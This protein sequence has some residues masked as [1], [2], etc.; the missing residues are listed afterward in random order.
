VFNLG[1]ERDDDLRN[2]A[3]IPT[4]LVRYR[5]DPMRASLID[6]RPLPTP[7]P[8]QSFCAAL[9]L[10]VALAGAAGGCSKEKE[11]LVVAA[12]T[13]ADANAAMKG[14]VALSVASVTKT[15]SLPAGLSQTPV[16]LGVY[17][18]ASVTGTV[19]ISAS[20]A[21]GDFCFSRTT[22]TSVPSAGSTVMVS[23]SLTATDTCPGI[24][25]GG[26]SGTGGLSETGGMSGGAG[27]PGTG[28]AAGGASGSSGSGGV[29][30]AGGVTGTGG[31]AGA[32]GV[33]GTGGMTGAGGVTGTGGMTGAGGAKGTGGMAGA[34][35]AKGTGGMAGAGGVTGTGGM[36]GAGGAGPV[37]PPS[38]TACVEYDHNDANDPPCNDDQG[39]SNWKILSLAF[40]PD[41][42][43]LAT[44]GNDG[45]V[46]IWN[47][48]GHTLTASG[49]VI[50][51]NG[52]AY[53]AFSPDGSTLVAG[54]AGVLGAYKTANWTSGPSFTGV[55]GQVQSM[56]VSADG[57]RIVTIDSSDNLYVHTL[58][59]GGAPVSY[60]IGI[61]PFS[62]S[63]EA[64][65]SATNIV[66]AVGFDTG[67][68]ATFQISGST[69]SYL[70]TFT[71]ETSTS[72]TVRAAAFAPMGTVLATGDND[73]K[74]QFWTSPINPTT[75][76]AALT[77]ATNGKPNEV[78]G[79]SWSRD[80]AYL[81]IAAGSDF[82]GG[83]ASIYAYPA[84]AR[85]AAV[86]PTYYPVSV[87]FSPSG[88]ALAIGEA[89]CGKVMLCAD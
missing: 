36:A 87:A 88:S 77:F 28:G 14:T 69:I 62:L 72:V 13:C 42:R 40:S 29:N 9:P 12:L 25:T 49:H 66:A 48:D 45:R 50:S 51:T 8:A 79:L 73:G 85:Y 67:R 61:D 11:S 21:T 23:L 18:P 2:P 33:T 55:T 47:F 24:G 4:R 89:T 78:A 75:I 58:V 86:V 38:L 37:T 5:R 17:L 83:S 70:S 59:S 1:G 6:R 31:M 34:G 15:F 81:A 76:G 32:G 60:S 52:Q 26:V 46:K 35:G 80:G 68:A 39:I 22:T 64:G 20:A 56:A 10:L 53:V 19:T 16:S 57:Q 74:L 84:R 44:A 41:G 82:A 54:S 3:L 30:G 43:T 7:L 65:S 63:L 71:V 27:G